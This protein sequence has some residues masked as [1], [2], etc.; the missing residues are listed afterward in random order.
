MNFSDPTNVCCND[1]KINHLF[2]L[3]FLLWM[4]GSYRLASGVGMSQDMVLV[5]TTAGFMLTDVATP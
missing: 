1:N 4:W 2:F 3:P 5:W